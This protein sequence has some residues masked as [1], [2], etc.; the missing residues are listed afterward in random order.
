LNF[1]HD[2][3]RALCGFLVSFALMSAGSTATYAQSGNEQPP[4]NEQPAATATPVE[5]VPQEV[6]DRALAGDND[7]LAVLQAFLRG[8]DGK[9]P[10]AIARRATALIAQIGREKRMHPRIRC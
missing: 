7:A 4:Q 8:T 5:V 3:R 2:Y 1:S 10:E 9:S 6:V